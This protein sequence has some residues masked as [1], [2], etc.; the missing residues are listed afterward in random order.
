MSYH[1]PFEEDI[2]AKGFP[3]KSIKDLPKKYQ[4][5]Y[6]EKKMSLKALGHLWYSDK[7]LGDF[8]KK[9]EKKYPNAIFA[10]TGDHFGRRFINGTPTL[11]EN[12]SVPFILYGKNIQHLSEKKSTPG[13]HID[14]APTLLELVAPEKTQFTSFGNSLFNKND[15]GIGYNKIITQN[16]LLEYS[17]NY[18]TKKQILTPKKTNLN[19]KA[20]KQKHDSLM[21]LAW[22]YTIKGDSIK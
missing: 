5:I 10:F 18:G 16:L 14:I 12:S 17:K 3:Y 8:V 20:L 11:Y 2:Y 13:S 19:E 15:V 6:N 7:A 1:P 9:A 22:Y 21:S 4:N